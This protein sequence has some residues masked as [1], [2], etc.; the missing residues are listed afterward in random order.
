MTDWHSVF[1]GKKITVMGLG[2]LGR[3]VGD[4]EFLAR[5][6]AELIVTDLKTSSEL[7]ASLVRLKPY[8]SIQFRLGEHVIDDFSDSDFILKAAGVPL[9]SPYIA[10]ARAQ[11]IPI[12]MSASWFA[13][14]SGVRTVGV[15]GTRGKTTVTYMLERIM[16]DAGTAVLFGGNIRGVSTLSLLEEVAPE[17]VALMELDS[18]QCQGW[19]EERMSPNIS[20]FTT[21]M[22]D[23]MNYYKDDVEAYFKDKAQIF[24]HQKQDDS[25]I[26]GEGVVPYVEEFIGHE[27]V[28]RAQIVSLADF[29]PSWKLKVIGAHNVFNAACARRAAQA[30]G[31]SEE[32]IRASLESFTGVP[33][34]LEHL[35]DVNGVSVYNDA[36]A[37][38]P[39]A[40]LAALEAL[41][42]RPTILIM[43]GADKG[44]NT[45]QL[46]EHIGLHAKRVILLEGS[47]TERMRQFLPDAAVHS[48]LDSAV[49]EAFHASQP[50]D[51]ILFSPAFASFGMFVNEYD[52]ND[53]F[54]KLIAGHQRAGV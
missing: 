13:E 34:R 32:S 6:G 12:K 45:K 11:G 4:A 14:L 37:T 15:T 26:L 48:T 22:R 36:T 49:S 21:F 17:S 47:G 40:T 46:L 8:S 9:D 18:W 41:L 39:E 1:S 28:A 44:L 29:P 43:G 51:V 52:R 50:G 33:G 16:K 10:H 23:H 54:V 30:L 7:E 25:L 24:V 53:Q 3:G 5:H 20:V 2:L 27:A 31:I 19:G 38:T 42:P 35:G